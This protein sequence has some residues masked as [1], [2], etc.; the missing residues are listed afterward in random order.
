[1]E[2]MIN[3]K[4]VLLGHFNRIVVLL[5][6]MEHHVLLANMGQLVQRRLIHVFLAKKVNIR[7][8][9]E[10]EN[11]F[12]VLQECGVQIQMLFTNVGKF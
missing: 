12:H 6:A 3:V 7:I 9:W 11:V 10:K 2:V 8:K 1:M 4:N 5:H